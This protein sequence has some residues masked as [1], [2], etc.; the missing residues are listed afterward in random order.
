MD[1]VRR[2]RDIN[3]LDLLERENMRAF[4]NAIRGHRHK[5]RDGNVML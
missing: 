5:Q 4:E 3:P 1:S 2:I